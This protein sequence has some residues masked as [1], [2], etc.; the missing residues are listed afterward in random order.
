M[1]LWTFREIYVSEVL[2]EK[3]R[4]VMVV[5]TNFIYV[6]YVYAEMCRGFAMRHEI[7]DSTFSRC[8]WTVLLR[9]DSGC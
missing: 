9:W 6:T 3:E 1:Y 7:I 5:R 8:R 4:R 2:Y